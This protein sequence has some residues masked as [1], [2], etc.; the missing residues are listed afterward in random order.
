MSHPPPSRHWGDAG[1][2]SQPARPRP[3]PAFPAAGGTGGSSGSQARVRELGQ[4]PSPTDRA[5]PSAV[6]SAA[7]RCPRS[8]A[9]QRRRGFHRRSG[10]CANNSPRPVTPAGDPEYTDKRISRTGGGGQKGG[11]RVTEGRQCPHVFLHQEVKGSRGKFR[12]RGDAPGRAPE[13]SSCSLQTSDALL[14][15][16]PPTPKRTRRWSERLG[17]GTRPLGSGWT[18]RL[19]LRKACLT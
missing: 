13:P 2:G 10:Y 15:S 8:K 16:R 5:H 12:D 19:C 3:P 4:Q 17:L 18:P 11:L 7:P 14:S 9:L 1:L 6:R